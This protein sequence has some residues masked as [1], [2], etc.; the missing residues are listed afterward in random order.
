MYAL[1]NLLKVIC[2][3]AGRMPIE[4]AQKLSENVMKAITGVTPKRKDE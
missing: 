4:S 2:V 3:E 1:M